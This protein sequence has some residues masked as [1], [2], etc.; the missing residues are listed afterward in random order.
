MVDIVSISRA[1]TDVSLIVV[2]A[3][4]IVAAV[5]VTMRYAPQLRAPR[6]RPEA[7]PRP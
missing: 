6:V 3:G 2:N 1:S 5:A 4:L 7:T